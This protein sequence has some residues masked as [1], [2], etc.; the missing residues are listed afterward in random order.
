MTNKD[1][2]GDVASIKKEIDKF[3]RDYNR[4]SEEIS[5]V[6]VGNKDIVK[7]I[8]IAFFANGHVLLEGVPGLGKTLLVKSLS[9]VLGFGF[10]RIQFTPDLIP[11]DITGFELCDPETRKS[12][13][14]KGPVFTNL[15]LA[16]EINR[17]PAK[18]QSAL[19]GLPIPCQNL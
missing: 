1:K 13:I 9:K 3:K 15:L 6:I 19:L 2:S 18:V 7:K 10:K 12:T 8:L 14:Q 17:A 4:I 16:D 5:K 11:S